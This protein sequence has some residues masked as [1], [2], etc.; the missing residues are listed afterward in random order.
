[1]PFSRWATE[2]NIM[3]EEVEREGG[4]K[5]VIDTLAK[6]D[7]IA[8]L[9]RNDLEA[10][11]RKVFLRREDD[12]DD[13]YTLHDEH[14]TLIDEPEAGC[15]GAGFTKESVLADVGMDY[16]VAPTVEPPVEPPDKPPERPPRPPEPPR[17]PRPPGPPGPPGPPRPPRPPGRRR[18]ELVI[19]TY[20]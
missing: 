13:R 15:P 2:A 3:A 10:P 5:E 11:L 16:Y 6:G 17:P 18:R 7:Y 12:E 9:D 4:I 14:G 1:M 8:L 20:F 19:F